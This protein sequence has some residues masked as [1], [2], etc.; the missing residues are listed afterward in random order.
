MART[1]LLQSSIDNPFTSYIDLVPNI[2]MDGEFQFGGMA[3][4]G[5]IGGESGFNLDDDSGGSSLPS[6]RQ[7]WIYEDASGSETRLFAG[8]ITDK[9]RQRR[10]R[11]EDDATSLDASLDDAN[12]ELRGIVVD[13]WTRPAET[14][15]HRVQAVM[16]TFLHGSPREST[17]LSNTWLSS[18]NTVDMPRKTYEATDPFGVIEDCANAAGKQFFVTVRHELFYDRDTSEDYA[19]SLAITDDAPNLTDEFPPIEPRAEEDGSEFFSRGKLRYGT[20]HAV[21]DVRS[22]PEAAHDYWAMVQYDGESKT[23]SD[24]T[25]RLAGTMDNQSVEE[26]T[27]HCSILLRADQTNLIAWGQTLLFRSAACGILTP[28]VRRVARLLWQPVSYDDTGAEG[29]LVHLE[30]GKPAKWRPRVTRGR[31]P[32]SEPVEVPGS[33]YGP[34]DTPDLGAD[35]LVEHTPGY[36]VEGDLELTGGTGHYEG[37]YFI[38][39]FDD[40]IT[41]YYGH[42]TK[43]TLGTA[44]DAIHDDIEVAGSINWPV[45]SGL[46]DW[47]F[48]GSPPELGYTVTIEFGTGGVEAFSP[49]NYV[50]FRY[51][52]AY[53]PTGSHPPT[54][55]V[56]RGNTDN[57]S[58]GYE[59]TAPGDPAAPPDHA[60][61]SVA[62]NWRMRSESGTFKLKFW[63]VLSGEPAYW[64]IDDDSVNLSAFDSIRV[65]ASGNNFDNSG[66]DTITFEFDI[67]GQCLEGLPVGSVGHP[68]GPVP[69][70]G[71]VDSSNTIFTT[72]GLI[73]FVPGTLRFWIDPDGDGEGFTMS[74]PATEDPEN[75]EGTLTTP[76]PTGAIVYVSFTIAGSPDPGGGGA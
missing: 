43:L 21:S 18:A 74:L 58:Q 72:P 34:C 54:P 67:T 66:G 28:V 31:P 57:G 11:W 22:G 48:G 27:E 71:D 29:Y 68:Y 25:V 30:L 23:A 56:I 40:P 69:A 1:V 50:Q 6:R 12:I 24:A 60:G 41:D 65:T 44:L 32:V 39:D 45:L 19:A 47:S 8:R 64:N 16:N 35:Q 73:P 52:H 10:S 51:T 59:D 61:A 36:D 75:G 53:D 5:E 13:R 70:G 55:S 42:E 33:T 46:F 9:G 20:N 17:D 2:A 76:P 14:D 37:S 4:Q 15:V 38:P 62:M 63:T 49:I 3:A 26:R 7:V